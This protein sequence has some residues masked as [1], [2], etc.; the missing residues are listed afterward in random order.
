M[1]E[2]KTRGE[3]LLDEWEHLWE[4][5]YGS[6]EFE[7]AYLKMADFVVEGYMLCAIVIGWLL[8]G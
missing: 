2:W 1:D 4:T 6:F 3:Y 5:S 7:Q 8:I